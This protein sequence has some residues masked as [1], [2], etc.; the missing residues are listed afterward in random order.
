MVI[1]A[2]VMLASYLGENVGP[3]ALQYMPE[4]FSAV[5]TIAVILAGIKTRF[6]LVRRSYW[7]V[8][9]ALIITV[10]CGI[11]ANAVGSGPII[12]GMRWYVRAFPLFFLPAVFPFTDKQIKQQLTL[13]SGF[14]LLQLPVAALQRYQG[15]QTG[16]NTGDTVYGTL[17]VSGTLTIF[18]LS[19][20]CIVLAM[21]VRG[22]LDKTKAIIL[23]LLF[24]I[25][26]T[27]N[28]TKITIFLLPMAVLITMLMGAPPGKRLRV[29]GLSTL[30]IAVAG[31]IFIPIYDYMGA[32][33][34]TTKEAYSIAD[35]F[36]KK[37]WF[38][39]YLA[40]DADVGSNKKDVGRVD[41]LTVPLGYITR[42]PVSAAF[43]LGIGNA[44][45]SSLG[46]QFSGD[47]GG[48]L[49]MYS[50]ATTGGALFLEL[51]ILGAVCLL[52]LLWMITSDSL[53]LARISEGLVGVIAVAW[54][55]VVAIVF[56]TMF[57][58]PT[59]YFESV[60]YL[61]W[62]FSGMIAAH[63]TELQLAAQRAPA[64]PSARQNSLLTEAPRSRPI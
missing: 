30:F 21:F 59:Y 43:G 16:H 13:L 26:T 14:G 7:M 32:Q 40:T 5:V 44:S 61:F 2:A 52:M 8:F 12:A 58:A 45:L 34:V 6:R 1:I 37:G 20:I 55:A 56:I 19:G 28:E 35:M 27:I 22:R 54:P 15:I 9:I 63:R 25:P 29:V 24:M 11:F 17:N 51:G 60:S 18:L 41:A 31:A 42:D 48:L 53:K 38:E 10:L 4:M 3:K 64:R 50:S 47:Y 57:Y 33:N 46:T 39:Q 23:A 62:Y 49:W 36:T